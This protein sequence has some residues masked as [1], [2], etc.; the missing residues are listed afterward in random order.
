MQ[1]RNQTLDLHKIMTNNIYLQRDMEA[2]LLEASQ[3]FPVI[4][5][6][7]SL[8]ALPLVGASC[9]PLPRGAP[10]RFLVPF[11]DFI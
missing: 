4:S 7:L 2:L 11:L 5:L 9:R 1:F 3:Y 10:S 6:S 8:S